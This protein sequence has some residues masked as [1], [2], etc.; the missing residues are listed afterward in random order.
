MQQGAFIYYL[1]RQYTTPR[2]LINMFFLLYFI[3]LKVVLT[4]RKTVSLAP[5]QPLSDVIG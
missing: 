3:F 4:T 5:T 1:V 2:R